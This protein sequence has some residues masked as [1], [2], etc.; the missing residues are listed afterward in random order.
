MKKIITLCLFVFALVLGTQTAVAQDSK[1]GSE[2]EINAIVNA[3]AAKKTESLIKF[4]GYEK[5]LSET[6]YDAVREHTYDTYLIELQHLTEEEGSSKKLKEINAK[7][8]NRMKAILTK[9]QFERY[10]R[11]PKS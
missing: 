6:V 3:K 11:F 4:V 9:A 2:K 10:L 1:F 8:E 5:H 7:L